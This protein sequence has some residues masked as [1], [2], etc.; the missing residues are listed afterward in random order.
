MAENSATLSLYN[1]LT[2]R[3]EPLRTREPGHVRL[4][5]CGVTVYDYAHVGHARVMVAFDTIVRFL[6]W[7]GQ[8]VTY[9]RNIT[10]IEDKIISRAR[11][12]GEKPEELSARF[13]AALHEDSEALGNRTP[14]V[15]PLATEHIPEMIKMITLLEKKGLAYRTPDGVYF[16]VGDFPEYGRLSRRNLDD[17]KAGARVE[18]DEHKR[19]PADFALWKAAK[20][21]E[22]FWPSP[23]GPGRP[24]WHIECSAMSSRYLGETFDLHGGGEDLIF[25]HHENEIAQ[26]EGSSGKPFAAHWAHCSFLRL[27]D[28][29]MSKSLGNIVNVRDALEQFPREALRLML[30]QTHYRSPLEFTMH[31]VGE[32]EKVLVR[33]YETLA[34]AFEEPATDQEVPEADQVRTDL[35]AALADD[36]N[37]PRALAA[38]HDGIRTVNRMMDVGY[39]AQAAKVAAAI[40][41][42][43]S[44]LGLLQGDP[45]ATLAEWRQER[46]SESGLDA[47]QIEA[48]IEQR[49]DARLEKN[50]ARADEIRAELTAAGI[51]LKDSPGGPTTWTA[52]R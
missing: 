30:V 36:M 24:G 17:L 20:Q 26:S 52:R 39:C 38:L 43:G 46:V 11:E 3:V 4:Y 35:R 23:F 6:E 16:A 14:D 51:E 12:N 19:H 10:D 2:R 33:M 7:E 32:A 28:E 27:G 44:V 29:K 15:E 37:T 41:D 50:F 13:A 40:V 1:T 42:A 8:R 47:A 22:P 21:G 18:V 31:A 48:L 9:V 5:V 25:P 45:A 49:A 34:R